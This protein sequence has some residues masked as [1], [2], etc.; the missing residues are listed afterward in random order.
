MLWIGQVNAL[1]YLAAVAVLLAAMTAESLALAA[2]GLAALALLRIGIGPLD[3]ALRG[4]GA[5]LLRPAP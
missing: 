4:R 5:R 1:C 3:A 2:A